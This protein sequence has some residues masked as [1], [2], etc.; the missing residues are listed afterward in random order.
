M[1]AYYA[2]T[3]GEFLKASSSQ[4]SGILSLANTRHGFLEV[5]GSQIESWDEEIGILR[6]QLSHL[7]VNMPLAFSWGILLEFPIP[8]RQ[9]RIDA[10]ILA[11]SLIFVFEFKSG[12]AGQSLAGVRQVEDY[13][14]DLAYFHKPSHNHIIFPVVIAPNIGAA[15]IETE[16]TEPENV[17]PVIRVKSSHMAEFIS[18]IVRKESRSA[19]P[20]IDLHQWNDG[21]YEPVPSVIEAATTLYAGMSVREIGRS[22]ADTHNLTKTT[23]FVLKVIADAQRNQQKVICFITGIP[24]AGKTLAGLNFVHNPEIHRDG[25]SASVFMSGNGP[26][27]DI[28]RE[29]L[30]LDCSART[31]KTKRETRTDVK[32]FI[33]NIHHFVADNLDRPDNQ[34]PYENAIVFDEAQ[35]AWN[36]E[37]NQKKY[38]KRGPA[39]H[40][41]E[42]EM[43]LRIMDR[44]S[45][46]AV[47]I[48]LVGGG[49]EIHDG[50][51]GLPEWGD[52]LQAKFPQWRIFAS[53]E[54]VDGGS[55]VAGATLFR[56]TNSDVNL[57]REPSLHLRTCIRSHHAP[58][59]TTW[60]NQ[61][62][63]GNQI[64]AAQTRQQIDVSAMNDT[65]EFLIDCG[66]NLID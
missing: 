60:V 31:G 19:S 7:C 55:S 10:I 39:W 5:D 3:I 56:S 11:G 24:G 42:P 66:A 59:V 64:S 58:Y 25:R 1:P 14:L 36:A 26:L 23:D 4:I 61:V 62:L 52:T 63:E 18:E 6:E 51:A 13:A 32:T 2:H 53:S 54:A 47:I 33:Q 41:S 40:V 28:L 44:H 49:Q 8:R 22:H 21:L 30:A 46:W 35:R 43:V 15:K 57:T 37:R 50:E 27:V 17:R 9:R 16:V 48:A 29:A 38:S 65:A 12:S 34:L 20:Q 45:D